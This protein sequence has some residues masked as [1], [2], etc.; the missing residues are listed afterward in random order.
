VWSFKGNIATHRIF[1][2]DEFTC[3]QFAK[4]SN[5]R[6]RFGGWL[7]NT[8]IVRY[9]G[10]KA[11]TLK[12]NTGT[13]EKG[14]KLLYYEFTYLKTYLD[15]IN[16]TPIGYHFPL[17]TESFVNQKSLHP[18]FQNLLS[19]GWNLK[20]QGQTQKIDERDYFTLLAENGEDLIGAIS[21]TKEN[22]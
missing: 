14:V 19:E 3:F 4:H 2:R 20:M 22:P 12:K 10:S 9:F 7:I 6:A 16:A 5:H 13:N 11:G 18:F 8:L 21:V 17:V 1:E 15:D